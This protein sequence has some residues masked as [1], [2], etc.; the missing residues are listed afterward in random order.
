VQPHQLLLLMWGLLLPHP[1]P[2]AQ[3]HPRH[4]L[5]QEVLLQHPLLL[6]H[7][8]QKMP[9]LRRMPLP[10]PPPPPLA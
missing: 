6:P 5:R 8:L 1:P 7:Q 10:L 3:G 4:L 9:P 2:S